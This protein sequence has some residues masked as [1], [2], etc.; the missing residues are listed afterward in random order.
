MDAAAPRDL[1]LGLLGLDTSHVVA[2]AEWFNALARAPGARIV[3]AWPGGSPEFALSAGRV[4]GFTARL[5]DDFGVAIRATPE[6]VAVEC[7]ALLLTSVDGRVH[8][9]QFER[10]ARFGRPVFVDKPLALTSADAREIFATAE[11]HGVRVCSSSALRFSTTFTCVVNAANRA[12][13]TGAEFFGPLTFEPVAPG[14]FW[15]AIHTVEMLYATLGRGCASVC[16][17]TGAGEDVISATWRDGR[18][19]VVR[20]RHGATH[21]FGGSVQFGGRIETVDIASAVT[22]FFHSLSEALL[23]FF[24]GGPAPVAAEETLELIRFLEAANESREHGGREVAL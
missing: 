11:R 1:K 21:A 19:G 3:A 12:E 23:T 5:R 17:T 4:A 2:F 8:R 14:Y 6:D 7:D 9:A 16:V 18:A 24:R 20:G 22:P 10:I 13:A 15:Y